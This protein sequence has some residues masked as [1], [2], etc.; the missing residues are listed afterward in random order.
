MNGL[1][2]IPTL[3]YSNQLH[4]GAKAK[5]FV[6]HVVERF[7]A[8]T[9]TLIKTDKSIFEKYASGTVLNDKVRVAFIDKFL[10]LNLHYR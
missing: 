6:F 3:Y 8:F 7:I 1:T 2:L 9:L 4:K 10:F 5:D